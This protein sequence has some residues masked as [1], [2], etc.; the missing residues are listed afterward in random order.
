MS[1]QNAVNQNALFQATS[2]T[3]GGES[4]ASPGGEKIGR[5][6]AKKIF[7]DEVDRLVQAVKLISTY[8]DALQQLKRTEKLTVQFTDPQGQP[9]QYQVGRAELKEFISQTVKQMQRLPNLAFTLNKTRRRTAPNSGFLAPARF[10]ADIVQFFATATIGPIVGGNFVMKTDKGGNR[11][12]VPESKSLQ[13]QQN[14]RLNQVLYFT[15]PQINNQANPLY[16]IISPGTLTPLF[17]LHAYY[18]RN[19]TEER[20]GLQN[21]DDAT[22]LTASNEMRQGLGTVMQRTIATDVA[23]LS[24]KYA[25]NQ[26]V[27]QQL[28]QVQQQ[29]IRA[30]G[31]PNLNINSRFPTGQRR[32]NGE[33]EY[34][35]IFNPNFFLYAHFSKLISNGKAPVLP[36]GQQPQQGQQY[37]LTEADLNQIRQQ[38]PAVYGTNVGGITA[39]AFQTIQVAA[40]QSHPESVPAFE[41]AVL[42]AQQNFV[43]LARAYKNQVQGAA[44]RA[45]R[46]AEKAQQRVQQQQQVAQQAQTGLTGVGGFNLP[47][48]NIMGNLPAAAPIVG[49]PGSGITV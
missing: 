29:L 2:P 1:N 34:D 7:K 39:S 31:D 45:R 35:E 22:R 36:L 12:M 44:Q 49:L 5:A 21:R 48:G 42:S 37:A 13:V 30:I 4:P 9:R 10:S 38:I 26:A 32:P 40:Q 14:T 19:P 24:D 6:Q 25:N 33:E 15:Q 47:A 16:G 11:K 3:S 46:A 28:Q 20:Q 8:S 18:A 43:A 27:L 23:T 41:H 17:A